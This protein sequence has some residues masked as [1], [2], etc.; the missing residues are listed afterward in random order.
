MINPGNSSQTNS[1]YPSY[2]EEHTKL[3]SIIKETLIKIRKETKSD[4]SSNILQLIDKIE[5]LNKAQMR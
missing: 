5:G 1:D 3:L 2:L 4:Q